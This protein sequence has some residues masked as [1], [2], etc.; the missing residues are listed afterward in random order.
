MTF[1]ALK[2]KVNTPIYHSGCH[3][4]QN[5][6]CDKDI[7]FRARLITQTIFRLTSMWLINNKT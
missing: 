4:I 1:H 6:Q 7:L 3:V 2:S 5:R